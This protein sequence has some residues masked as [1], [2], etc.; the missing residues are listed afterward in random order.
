MAAS[1]SLLR[2]EVLGG[3]ILIRAMVPIEPPETPRLTGYSVLIAAGT[4]DPYAPPETTEK[5]AE[6]LRSGGADVTVR[7]QSAGHNLT[8]DEVE[9]ARAWLAAR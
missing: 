8:R 7:Y 6:M 3:A 2:P 1:L 9:A 4:E 5:L